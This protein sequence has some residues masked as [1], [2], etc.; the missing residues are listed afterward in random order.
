M[1]DD[2][3]GPN[4]SKSAPPADAD[5]A[6]DKAADAA[7]PAA[8]ALKSSGAVDAA[9]LVET[10]DKGLLRKIVDS[11]ALVTALAM[12]CAL[13]VGSILIAAVDPDVQAAAQYFFGRP[14]DTL[15]AVWESISGA[16]VAL[17]QGAVLNSGGGNITG[18]L[19]PLINSVTYSAPLILA[20][21][22]ISVAFRAGM[23]NI[24][25]Q[26][27]AVMGTILSAYI[28]FAWNLPPVLHLF[29]AILGGIL[30]GGLYAGIAGALKARFGAHEVI[31][32]I[33][34]NSIAVNFVAWFLT[35]GPISVGGQPKSPPLASSA[36][37]PLLMGS[38]FKLHLGVIVALLAAVFVWWLMN[39]STLG[40]V[41]RAVGSN[42]D[43]ARTA[44]MSVPFATFSV[45][46][47]SGALC[48]L[49]GATQVLGTEH[50]L[51]AEIVGTMGFDAITVA[52]LGRSRPVGVVFAGLLFS[53][54]TTGG[55]FMQIVTGTPIDIVQVVQ[56]M[57]VLFIAA[58]PLVKA[59]FGLSRKR[60]TPAIRTATT[61]TQG[62]QA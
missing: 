59:I 14:G 42:A 6:A 46:V 43:A 16:Y 38:Y 19:E 17:F 13:I 56:A 18:V 5:K 34:L 55:R 21:L 25:G 24:G 26:G 4:L 29:V 61:S 32:T 1:S 51:T 62:A 40:F 28:G 52:L 60:K 41:Y 44:G 23:F 7:T 11:S 36:Q 30:A 2:N 10:E 54:L 49:A 48:G 20:A 12:V 58:P 39:R 22:G 35:L 53:I 57:I 15:T 37:Y 9:R 45:M 3:R 27:Q 8:G 33:M 50:V 47:I 31:T